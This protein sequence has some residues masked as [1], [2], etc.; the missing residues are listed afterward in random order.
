MIGTTVTITDYY[1]FNCSG[2]STEIKPT[3]DSCLSPTETYV[4][5][6]HRFSSISASS[7]PVTSPVIS[8]VTS[9]VKSPTT[10][11]SPVTSPVSTNKL[12][13]Y[14]TVIEYI[15][16]SCSI[17]FYAST[18]LLD[19]C[20]YY[21]TG[22]KDEGKYRIVTATSSSVTETTYTNSQCTLGAS[23]ASYSYTDGACDSSDSTKVYVSSSSVWNSGAVTAT[24]R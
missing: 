16:T 23:P 3:L 17:P 14:V 11:T 24:L 19:T 13:G 8:P 22:K 18:S 10:V 12:S 20:F 1:Y 5:A 9:P 15:D 6:Y 7:S 2:T 21:D 4:K